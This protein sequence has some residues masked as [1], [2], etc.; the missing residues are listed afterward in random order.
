[1]K[2]LF[3][4]ILIVFLIG[5]AV[6]KQIFKLETDGNNLRNIIVTEGEEFSIQLPYNAGTQYQWNLKKKARMSYLESISEN[7]FRAD[8][9]GTEFLTGRPTIQEFTFKALKP[10]EELHP[11]MIFYLENADGSE[12]DKRSS[13][14]ITI[15]PAH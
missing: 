5:S 7:F 1:M 10:T 2:H 11:V 12:W 3:A 14:F 9:E 6:S 8:E 13:A 15:K 4:P